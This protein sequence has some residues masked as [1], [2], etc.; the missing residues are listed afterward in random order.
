MS[1]LFSESVEQQHQYVGLLQLH[2]VLGGYSELT[3]VGARPVPLICWC[4]A[5]AEPGEQLFR[6]CYSAGPGWDSCTTGYPGV[7]GSSTTVQVHGGH[8][9]YRTLGSS[10]GAGYTYSLACL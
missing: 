3:S 6:Q 2:Q 7:L 4:M 10:C 1:P 5:V 9:L 8:L